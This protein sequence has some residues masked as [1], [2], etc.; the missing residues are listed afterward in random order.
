M[1]CVIQLHVICYDN[2]YYRK[3]DKGV[4]FSTGINS[5]Y[6]YFLFVCSSYKYAFLK[7]QL[8]TNIHKI[9][10]NFKSTCSTKES[11]CP[12]SHR[13]WRKCSLRS[14]DYSHSNG[15]W[16]CHYPCFSILLTLKYPSFHLSYLGIGLKKSLL[17]SDTA[18]IVSFL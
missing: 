3:K 7:V 10:R 12:D 13:T 9:P 1:Q 17:T 16:L 6:Y 4:R 2:S 15:Y 11:F 8:K 18:S 14:F 5:Y